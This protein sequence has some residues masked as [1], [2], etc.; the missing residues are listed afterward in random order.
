MIG[1]FATTGAIQVMQAA[2]GVLL[3]RKLGPD[4]RGELA[5]IVLWPTLLATIGSLGMYAA[6]TYE[7]A[8]SA[9]LGQIVG[10]TLAIVAAESVV[11]VGIGLLVIPLALNQQDA[12]V[13]HDARIFLVAY[14]PFNLIGISMIS[15][16]NGIHRFG[17]FQGLRLVQ[18]VVLVGSLVVLAVSGNLRVGTAT[19]AYAAGFGVMTVIATARILYEVRGRLGADRGTARSLLGF[20][21]KSQLSTSLWSVNERADQLVISV[22]FSPVSLGLYVVAVTMTALTTL[23]GFS[24]AL[25]ALPIVARLSDPGERRRTARLLV[26]AVLFV[27]TAIT[28]PIFIAEPAL[29]R[30]LFGADFAGA[31][32][33]GRILLVASIAFSLNRVL[34]ALL[35]GMGHPLESS[36]GEGIALALT[37]AGLAILLPTVGIIGAG[38]TSL[39]AYSASAFFLSR[40]AARAFDLTVAELFRPDRDMLSQ[41]R[42]IWPLRA[43]SEDITAAQAEAEREADLP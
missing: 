15:T 13:V 5:A 39:V 36:V 14:I 22:F 35:Q 3:A 28:V 4:H 6:V 26:A 29:I 43:R 40:R 42:G 25:V 21:L 11:L 31:A 37:A 9:R 30:L 20:G 1:S 34:E 8:R 27:S 24:T 2:M 19:A 7:S 18:I 12:A 32:D 23:I 16:L 10:T 33:V 17:W 41:L 38:I